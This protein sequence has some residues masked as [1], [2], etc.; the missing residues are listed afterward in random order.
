[1]KRFIKENWLMMLLSLFV[2]ATLTTVTSCKHSPPVKKD[3]EFKTYPFER[4]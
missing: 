2:C 4:R 3:N 1:M